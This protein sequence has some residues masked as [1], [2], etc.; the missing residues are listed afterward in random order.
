MRYRLF[1]KGFELSQLPYL[2]VIFGVGILIASIAGQIVGETRNTGCDYVVD[3]NKCMT[4]ITTGGCTAGCTYNS[5]GN[6]CYNSS[7]TVANSAV[8][9]H[10]TEWNI[11][12][13]GMLGQQKFANWFPTI[14]LV[15]GAVIIIGALGLLF[16]LRQ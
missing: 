3:D 13:N 10:N 7:G 12:E 15:I 2:A 8:T 5:S 11:S 6:T 1:K 4:C 16:K 14:G 9:S